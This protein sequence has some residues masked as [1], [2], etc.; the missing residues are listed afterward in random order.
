[1]NSVCMYAGEGVCGVCKILIFCVH[2]FY[3][4][5][6]TTCMYSISPELYMALQAHGAAMTFGLESG[7]VIS[8]ADARRFDLLLD[9][10][11]TQQGEL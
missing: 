9:N 1:M 4:V 10:P 11:G 3:P 8:E 2:S 6:V 7:L 5:S